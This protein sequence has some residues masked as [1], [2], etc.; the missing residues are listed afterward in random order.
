MSLYNQVA[1]NL[2]KRN[3]AN[4]IGG[5][6]S[7][8][9]QDFSKGV[10]EV[11]G[12]GTFGEAVSRQISGAAESYA[13]GLI[14]KYSPVNLKAFNAGTGAIGDILNGDFN[15]AGLR[16]FDSGLLDQYF[17]GISGTAAQARY[18]STP[19]PML[20]GITPAKA[21][22]IFQQMQAVD[23]SRKNLFLL[24]VSSRLGKNM[25]SVFNLFAVDLEFSPYSIT[26]E[27]KKIG[28]AS[29]DI[30]NSSDPI[31]M[32]IT[33]YDD[34]TGSLKNWFA[35]HAQAAA[36]SVD[37]TVG[38]PVSYLIDISVVHGFVTRD[39]PLLQNGFYQD[40]GKFRASNI[41]MSLSRR[42]NALQELQMSF[43]QSDTFML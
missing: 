26:G 3:L 32:R 19:N 37:G 36:S 23:Y 39:H 18:F 22:E 4:S 28:S 20:G 35:A 17:P 2:A 11:L 7:S 33:T 15:N 8:V 41:D 34:P 6:A 14:N 31:E 24:E 1:D 42:E 30:V 25:S 27:K 12:G 10:K 29:S 38:L 40:K 13:T 21:M 9:L 43:V 5:G 16:I